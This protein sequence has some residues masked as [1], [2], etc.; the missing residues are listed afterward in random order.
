MRIRAPHLKLS[1]RKTVSHLQEA[2]NYMY[3]LPTLSLP[4]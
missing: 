2:P 3:M 4:F 1:H